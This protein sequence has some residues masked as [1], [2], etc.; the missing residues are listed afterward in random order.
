MKWVAVAMLLAFAVAAQAGSAADPPTATI[1]ANFV[2]AERA[3]HYTLEV[4]GATAKP[5]IRWDLEIRLIPGDGGEID[6]DCTITNTN[7]K[8]AGTSK[9]T[10]EF[11]W[12]HG[13]DDR[14]EDAKESTH[15]H[16]GR[17]HARATFPGWICDAFYEGSDPGNSFPNGP[18]L[19]C[20]SDGT[21]PPPPVD[22]CGK[23]R[24]AVA[25][26]KANVEAATAR[27]Q[28]L[29][30]DLVESR[31]EAN[32]AADYLETAKLAAALFPVVALVGALNEASEADAN[33]SLHK[34]AVE[35]NHADAVRE[36]KSAKEELTKAEAALRAC[37]GR[38]SRRLQVSSTIAD[39]PVC[40]AEQAS[41]AATRSRAKVLGGAVRSFE[42]TKAR[43]AEQRL[44][45]AITRLQKANADP[46]ASKVRAKVNIALVHLRK[47]DALLAGLVRRFDVLAKSAKA[48]AAA[49]PQQQAALAKCVA[50][51]G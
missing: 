30:K 48:A 37:E 19:P 45:A 20:V 46:R 29:A 33:W 32:A 36:L 23:E 49:V 13:E 15:G 3:T 41:L 35:R 39:P 2:S 10:L 43:S 14:C 24:I 1:H 6:D 27:E 40:V 38:A 5:S 11:I 51:S 50:S 12:H 31:K 22:P 44:H 9:E 8:D 42:R 47:L 26:A 17:I 21:P 25:E 16:Q 4:V 34:S 7:V 28:A 18:T